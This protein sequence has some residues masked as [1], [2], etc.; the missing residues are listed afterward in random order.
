MKLEANLFGMSIT[1][2]HLD[3]YNCFRKEWQKTS[4][5]KVPQS[6]KCHGM[7]DKDVIRSIIRVK[8][9]Y[10]KRAAKV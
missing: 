3:F 1:R 9:G 6:A 4:T 7:C 5:N 10:K 8:Q 2:L